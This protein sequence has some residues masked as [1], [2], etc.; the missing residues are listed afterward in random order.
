MVE[1]PA[2]RAEQHDFRRSPGYGEVQRVFAVRIVFDAVQPV[3]RQPAFVPC[4]HVLRD[5]IHVA[6]EHIRLKPRR[7]EGFQPPVRRN[8][9]IR[10]V[11]TGFQQLNARRVPTEHNQNLHV[12]LP[13]Q[14]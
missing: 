3:L 1:P 7:V 13:A 8:G 4:Q 12:I 9:K 14:F 10:L 5:G 2:Q 11:C 6:D